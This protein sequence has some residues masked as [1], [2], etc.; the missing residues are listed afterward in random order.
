MPLDGKSGTYNPTLSAPPP[1]PPQTLLKDLPGV[2]VGNQ[3]RGA[4]L[5]SIRGFNKDVLAPAI[6]EDKSAPILT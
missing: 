6:T 2:I 5:A 4:L 3:E 1:P